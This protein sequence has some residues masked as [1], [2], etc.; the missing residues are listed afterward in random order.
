MTSLMGELGKTK[1][2]DLD[3]QQQEATLITW[4][5]GQSREACTT[6]QRLGPPG[7]ADSTYKKLKVQKSLLE[8]AR[9]TEEMQPLPA[10]FLLP[11]NLLTMA[12]TGHTL[13][14][15]YHAGV[16][17]EQRVTGCSCDLLQ[18]L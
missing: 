15:K 7:K 2:W 1:V 5:E 12:S 8:R 16:S 6:A 18:T 9:T 13:P 17:S 10:P 14:G 4:L 11:F 3:G